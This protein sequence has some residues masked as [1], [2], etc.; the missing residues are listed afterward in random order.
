[1]IPLG[2]I[3]VIDAFLCCGMLLIPE[4]PRWLLQHDKPE[5]ARKVLVWLRPDQETVDKEMKDIQHGIELEQDLASGTSVWDMFAHP[6]DRRPTILAI[7]AVSTQ[8]AS[9][10]MHIIGQLKCSSLREELGC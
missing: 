7:A 4:S 1:M 3:F 2:I 10:A 6:V 8:A 5:E 9:G